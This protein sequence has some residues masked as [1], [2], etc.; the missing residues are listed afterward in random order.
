[1]RQ[2]EIIIGGDTMPLKFTHNAVAELEEHAGMGLQVLFEKAM[3]VAA[4]RLLVWAAL[5][6]RYKTLTV[7]RAGDLIQQ[8]QENEGNGSIDGLALAVW[9]ALRIGGFMT[10]GADLELEATASRPSTP[11]TTPTS[12]PSPAPTQS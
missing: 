6:H 8:Y 5:R 11:T 2:V 1:M 4:L 12:D 9:K 3:S 7:Q 10:G